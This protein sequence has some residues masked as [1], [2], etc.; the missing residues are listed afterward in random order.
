MMATPKSASH[1]GGHCVTNG[2]ISPYLPAVLGTLQASAGSR[3]T[4][5]TA[6]V[7]WPFQLSCVDSFWAAF[8]YLFF[9]TLGGLSWVQELGWG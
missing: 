7:P 8:I 1:P 9:V 5:N 4:V 2:M 3:G 6:I